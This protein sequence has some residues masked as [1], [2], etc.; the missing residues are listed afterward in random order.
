MPLAAFCPSLVALSDQ[1]PAV[2]PVVRPGPL[3]PL[4]QGLPGTL[5][6]VQRRSQ[7]HHDPGHLSPPPQSEPPKDWRCSGLWQTPGAAQPCDGGSR[8]RDSSRAATPLA[9][10]RALGTRYSL[11]RSG[12]DP[13]NAML[14][15]H[16][17]P[18]EMADR[19][20]R[21]ITRRAERGGEA[22]VL[23]QPRTRGKNH[24][25]VVIRP[26]KP[27]SL[28]CVSVFCIYFSHPPTLLDA[29]RVPPCCCCLE[30]R[31]LGL[32]R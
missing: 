9:R 15:G 12:D 28:D 24:V 29:G 23:T 13:A 11:L 5:K 25:E 16:W 26:G 20:I 31:V 18:Y 14:G 8:T 17:R 7:S 6:L 30:S 1:Q 2:R 27:S 10:T 19:A 22:C 3:P 21:A 4:P 32:G